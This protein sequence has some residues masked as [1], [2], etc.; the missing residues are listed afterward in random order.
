MV[1]PKAESISS[2]AN[3]AK[4]IHTFSDSY[5]SAANMSYRTYSVA[6]SGQHGDAIQLFVDKLNTLQAQLFDSYPTALAAY[7][8]TVAAYEQAL[9]GHGFHERMWS[10]LGEATNL[11][12]LYTGDQATEISDRVSEMN[13]LLKAGAEAAG[14]EAPDLTSIQSTATEGFSTAGSDRVNLATAVDG[15]WKTFTGTLTENAKTIQA[16][17]SLINHVIYFTQV[18]PGDVA[19]RMTKGHLPAS[20]MYYLDGIN[21]ESDVQAVKLLMSEEDYPNKANFFTDLGRFKNASQM[22]EGGGRCDSWPSL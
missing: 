17:Q 1:Y 4:D 14:V 19:F 7:A 18:T 10:D 22:S 3:Y 20:R 6:L 11:K 13:A 12:T 2:L 9:T 5:L 21:N 16:F 15:E 8:Q